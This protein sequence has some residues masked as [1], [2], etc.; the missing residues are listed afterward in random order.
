MVEGERWAL[1]TLLIRKY[2]NKKSWRPEV[3]GSV[4]EF[5]KNRGIF[6]YVLNGKQNM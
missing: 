5:H 4:T 2:Y 1:Y 6:S 3:P